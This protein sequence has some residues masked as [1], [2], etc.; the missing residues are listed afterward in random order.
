MCLPR[1]ETTEANEWKNEN[2]PGPLW[3]MLLLSIAFGSLM[4]FCF[5]VKGK[6]TEIYNNVTKCSCE[7]K[8]FFDN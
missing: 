4:L 3:L 2:N 8:I 7:N 5:R 1:D 6:N